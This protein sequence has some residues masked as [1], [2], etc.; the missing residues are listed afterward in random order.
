MPEGRAL[1]ASV[2]RCSS[3]GAPRVEGGL[4]CGFCSADFT[5]HERDLHTICPG[6]FARISDRARF[7]HHCATPILV[8]GSA[9]EDTD[10]RCPACGTEHALSSRRL[11]EA[12]V[13]VLECGR[14]AGLWLGRKTLDLLEE[15]AR[16]ESS[17]SPSGALARSEAAPP[18]DGA[19]DRL[20]RPCPLCGHLMHRQN[21]GRRS[22]VVVDTCRDDG[23][24][25]DQGE[26]ARILA[27]T[28][29]GG[30]ARNLEAERE[31]RRHRQSMESLGSPLDDGSS[32]EDRDAF[33][34]V[35]LAGVVLDLFSV[36]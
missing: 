10:L 12:D 21:Y 28:R 20:Y 22:G 33:A 7:C 13:A 32:R 4:S 27:W 35:D 15:R 19:T 1:D 23:V 26:L 3:C 9:G 24:W 25:F 16:A 34:G 29:A 31:E 14:C 2:V 18:P 11:G 8:E 5:L 6:C 17:A 36:F 30:H